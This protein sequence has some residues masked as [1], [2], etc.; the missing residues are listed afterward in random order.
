MAETI[1]AAPEL[2]DAAHYGVDRL[3]DA[4]AALQAARSVSAPGEPVTDEQ[5]GR[6]RRLVGLAEDRVN[7]VI[8]EL[9]PLV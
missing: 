7:E 8:Q 6:V 3:F 1:V 4:L 9:Q 5:A 2:K